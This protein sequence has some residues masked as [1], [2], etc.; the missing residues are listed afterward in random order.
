LDSQP[1]YA[2]RVGG[3]PTIARNL[4]SGRHSTTPY[5]FLNADTTLPGSITPGLRAIS[6][7]NGQRISAVADK[8]PILPNFAANE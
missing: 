8:Y 3:V 2:T 4:K 7:G 1:Y 5:Q 6:H